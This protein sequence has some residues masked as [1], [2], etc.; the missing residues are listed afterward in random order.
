[1]VCGAGVG[2]L[3]TALALGSAGHS[4]LVLEQRTRPAGI[5]TCEVL[6]PGSIGVLR[7]LGVFFPLVERGAVGLDRL[8]VRAADG[9]PV[10]LFDYP[11]LAGPE[12]SLLALDHPEIRGALARALPDTVRV[13][14]GAPAGELLRDSA[15]RVG[16]VGYCVG[17]QWFSAR[18]PLVVAADGLCS[19]VRGLAGIP[20]H[21][22]EYRHRLV[23]FELTGVPGP[24]AE[25][26]AYLTGR[27]LR[28]TYPLPRDRVRLYVQ[29][30]RGLVHNGLESW[31]AGL[32]DDAPALRPLLGPVRAALAGRQLLS[33][34]RF[35]APRLSVPGLALV[36][37]TAYSAHVLTAQGLN[38]AIADAAALATAVGR[39]PLRPDTV[40]GALARYQAERRAWI[41]HID[42]ISHDAARLS[43]MT[44]RTGR[45]LGRR[46]LDRT[47]DNPRLRQSATYNLAGLDIRPLRLLDRLYRLG[48][49]DPSVR[50][51]QGIR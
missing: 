11:D 50:A 48:L 1:M 19:R 15:G 21:P 23:S 31:W 43:T 34:W 27:G 8:T 26:T 16:G 39:A 51:R 32:A 36:G 17:G 24:P 14:R 42:L 37:E 22:V 25:V 4:V 2:G 35:T 6:Q 12:R 9:A 33:M 18:A 44:S 38:A 5:A 13:R 28:L 30:P 10:L 47:N 45:W 20:A 3:T 29:V 46:L 7:A 40:D 49:P 41:R